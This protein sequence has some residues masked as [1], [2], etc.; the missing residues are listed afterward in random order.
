MIIEPLDFPSLAAAGTSI[1]HKQVSSRVLRRFLDTLGGDL[2]NVES[3]LCAL[4]RHMKWEVLL[5]TVSSF[6][7]E[8]LST[9]V[10]GYE[11]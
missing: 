3:I 7:V 1:P 6:E 2:Q 9:S 8:M 11:V 4:L 5:L 10:S